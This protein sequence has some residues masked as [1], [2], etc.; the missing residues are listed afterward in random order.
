MDRVMLWALHEITYPVRRPEIGVIK[1]LALAANRLNHAAA[2]G[3]APRMEN[4]TM[5]IIM[6]FEAISR[7]CL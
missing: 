3:D 4:N 2:S 5:L 1:E 7:G 6:E